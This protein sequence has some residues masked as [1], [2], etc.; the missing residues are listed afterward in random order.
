MERLPGDTDTAALFGID[1]APDATLD[2]AELLLALPVKPPAVPLEARRQIVEQ[3]LKE[4]YAN[5]VPR[6]PDA[7]LPSWWPRRQRRRSRMSVKPV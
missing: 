2:R 7:P 5:R 1:L 6:S 3:R 4:T